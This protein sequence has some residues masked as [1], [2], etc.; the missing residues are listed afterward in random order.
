MN[1][2]RI[3][4]IMAIGFFPLVMLSQTL[5]HSKHNLSVSGTGTIRAS[6][7][8]EIC[9]FCHTPHSSNGPV[10]PLWNRKDPG[11]VYTLYNSSTIDA[12][13][14]QPDGSSVLCLSC[15]D[16]TIA[17]GNVKSRATDIE[18]AAG[19]TTMPP[20]HANLTTDLSDDHPVSFVYD[21]ALAAKDGQLTDPST[22]TKPVILENGKVQCVSCHDPHSDLFNNFLVATNQGS[23]LCIR[24]HDMN[25]WRTSSHNVSPAEWNGN[26]TDPWPHTP[27]TTV[28]DNACEN[29]HK[30]HSAEGKSRLLNYLSEE[31]N[32][33]VCH[34]GNVAHTDIQSQFNKTYRHNVF[35]YNMQHD[36]AEDAVVQTMHVECQDCHNPHSVRKGNT[37]APDIKGFQTNVEGVN[38]AGTPVYPAQYEYEICFRCHADSPGKPGSPTTRQI[39]QNNVRLEFDVNNPSFH[40]VEGPGKNS[41]SPSLISPLT[42]SSMIYCTDCHSSDGVHAPKGPHGSNYPSLLKYRYETTDYTPESELAYELCYSCHDRNSILNDESFKYHYLHIKGEDTPCN[43]CHDPH[44]ISN[45]QGSAT[46][47]SHLINFDRD[48]VEPNMR[49]ELYFEDRGTFRGNCSLK[50]HGKQHRNKFY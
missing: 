31:N 8:T 21:P 42:E 19:V 20:G 29:C 7:E 24:C 28:L 48:V 23:D 40:P 44:G 41:N 4:S 14:G 49:G 17:L 5:V 22:I 10:A 47:N 38:S 18:F 50:C 46:N 9:I 26:G 33:L 36:P 1:V 6:S 12:V 15:H 13:P 27:Y 45:T 32:C 35:N 2:T 37:T 30:P 16:G 11:V 25:N 43:V 34:N 3:I 39:E